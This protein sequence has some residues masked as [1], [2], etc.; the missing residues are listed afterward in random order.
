LWKVA[1]TTSAVLKPADTIR[2]NNQTFDGPCANLRRCYLGGMKLFRKPKEG[3]PVVSEEPAVTSEP[4]APQGA[5]LEDIRESILEEVG[6]F[7]F[8]LDDMLQEGAQRVVLSPRQVTKVMP[9]TESTLST[10]RSRGRGPVFLK[11]GGTVGYLVDDV[12]AFIH[13]ARRNVTDKSDAAENDGPVDESSEIAIE[14][15]GEEVVDQ[16]VEPADDKSVDDADSRA[17]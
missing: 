9:V 2:N 3:R 8:G 17:A 11:I 13:D 6:R 1:E 15:T 16:P 5:A 12:A 10:W 14:E 7:I 4:E